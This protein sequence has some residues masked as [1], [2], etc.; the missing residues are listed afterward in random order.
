MIR[1][2]VHNKGCSEQ[3]KE[4]LKL[5]KMIELKSTEFKTLFNLLQVMCL[6]KI[7]YCNKLVLFT[8]FA[9]YFF[10]IQNEFSY[11]FKIHLDIS[12]GFLIFYTQSIHQG[13]LQNFSHL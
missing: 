10:L 5:N 13:K 3:R 8:K 2:F 12:F 11:K 9:F 6:N 7:I 1:S 4:Y